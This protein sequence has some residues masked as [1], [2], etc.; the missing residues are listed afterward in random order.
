MDFLDFWHSYTFLMWNCKC[1]QF[2]LRLFSLSLYL[3]FLANNIVLLLQ[4]W[5]CFA[6]V[7]NVRYFFSFWLRLLASLET[8]K[9]EV[10][11][12]LLLCSS[13]DPVLVFFRCWN[14]LWI[15]VMLWCRLFTRSAKNVYFQC[16]TVLKDYGFYLL[17]TEHIK[18]RK[19]HKQRKNREK[20]RETTN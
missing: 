18:S 16:F 11:T 20:E 14:L 1:D 7:L 6:F 8:S 5:C 15:A 2:N 19:I 13:F 3:L 9:S 12:L 10:R 4:C 17:N